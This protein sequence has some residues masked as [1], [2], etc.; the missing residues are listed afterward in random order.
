MKLSYIRF[1]LPLAVSLALPGFLLTSRADDVTQQKISSTKNSAIDFS[2]LD[3]LIVHE[4]GRQKPFLVFA[5]E[6]TLALTGKRKFKANDEALAAEPFITH[7][8]LEGQEW[9]KIPLIYVSHIPLKN[10]TGLPEATSHFSYYDLA[11]NTAF[12]QLLNEAAAARAPKPGESSPKLTGL[13]KEVA[14]VGMRMALYENI[15]RGRAPRLRPGE[16]NNWTPLPAS[17]PHI[18]ALIQAL[19][20]NDPTAFTEAASKLQ[21]WQKQL[22][23]E[24]ILS[25]KILTLEVLYQKIHPFRIAWIF[26]LAAGILLVVTMTRS[27]LWLSRPGYILAWLLALVGLLFQIFGFVARVFIAG[28]APVT[29][30]YESVIWVAF[31]TVFFAL[32]FELKSRGRYFLLGAIPVAVLSLILADGYPHALDPS[33]SPLVPVLKHNFWLTTHVLTITLS[34][35]AFALALGVAHIPLSLVI[36]GKK[37]SP[38]LYQYVY[39]ALQV[40]V[41]LLALGTILGGVWANYSWGRFWDWDPKETW[42][43]IALLVY[44]FILHGR[45][46]GRWSGFGTAVGAILGFQSI[47]MAWYGV[48]FVLGV[49]LHSY[50]FGTGGRGMALS[51]VTLEC[52]FVAF[53]IVRHL[54]SRSNKSP[55]KKVAA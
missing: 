15:T 18:S 43:L 12:V 40:G 48:N 9:D 46:A 23:P 42:A 14:E 44:L 26:Y 21:D 7:L 11:D 53:A 54:A 38:N 4:G 5:E 1:V 19:K 27:L 28:R 41:L 16:S 36:L 30:M 52:I 51:F 37:P 8:W 49:G 6:S 32:L 2:D 13:L 25:P 45:I 17:D 47:I 31:G 20:N 39:R 29:N 24:K 55:A 34:Y 50:G 35:A 22:A 3:T 33:I 10:E